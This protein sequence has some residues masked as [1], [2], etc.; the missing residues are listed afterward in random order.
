MTIEFYTKENLYY[1]FSNFYT[2]N[3]IN[4]D[5][6]LWLNVEHYFQAQKFA[7]EP[8]YYQIIQACDSPQKFKNLGCQ[9]KTQFSGKWVVNK[10]LDKRL[11]ND[12]VTQYKHLKIREDW[13]TI[14]DFI[15]KKALLAKFTQDQN[16]KK[17]LLDTDNREIIEAS[18]KD[19]YWGWG[20]NKDGLNKLGKLLMEVREEIV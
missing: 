12:I 3:L 1:E 10:L 15:M 13:D 19:S 11:L 2:K 6:Y 8:E 5:N 17:L 9:K 18:P 14:R 4:I 7:H 20:K 16:L